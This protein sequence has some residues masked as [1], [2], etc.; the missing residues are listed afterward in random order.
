MRNY[1]FAEV[2][3]RASAEMQKVISKPYWFE[4]TIDNKEDMEPGG[5]D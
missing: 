5:R 4:K 3:E 2:Y 1:N